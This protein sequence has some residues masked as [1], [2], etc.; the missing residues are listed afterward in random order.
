M[1]DK[2]VIYEVVFLALF[3]LLSFCSLASIVCLFKFF[4]LPFYFVA[5]LICLNEFLNAAQAVFFIV[6]IQ[7]FSTSIACCS[8]AFTARA[9][10]LIAIDWF[11]YCAKAGATSHLVCVNIRGFWIISG[12]RDLGLRVGTLIFQFVIFLVDRLIILFYFLNSFSKLIFLLL[13][14]FQS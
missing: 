9:F 1:F 3:K 12:R 4:F 6:Y 13:S 5:F 2:I 8:K 11:E 10:I 7:N 14:E